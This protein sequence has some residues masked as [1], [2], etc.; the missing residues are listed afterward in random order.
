MITMMA[1]TTTV[2]KVR[3]GETIEQIAKQYGVSVDAIRQANP[4]M[5]EYFYIGMNLIIPERWKASTSETS[6]TAKV[7]QS[8]STQTEQQYQAPPVAEKVY[9]IPE[10]IQRKLE[11]ERKAETY[12]SSSYKRD[13]VYIS[14]HI[15]LNSTNLSGDGAKGMESDLGYSIGVSLDAWSNQFFGL[16]IG[17]YYNQYYIVPEKKYRM[18]MGYFEMELL[19]NI[20]LPLR[21]DLAALLEVNYGVSLNVGLSGSLYY[22]GDRIKGVEI[23][24]GTKTDALLKPTSAMLLT[25][26][27]FRWK[28]FFVRMLLHEGLTNIANKGKNKIKLS[29]WEFSLGFSY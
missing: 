14:S 29:S 22:D 4:N 5:G 6:T 21:K 28:D 3:K 16:E 10:P 26:F 2:H 13:N 8:I 23:I 27:T 11:E 25:G 12:T 1:Q 18:K 9:S 24:G 19:P 7:E 15:A 17:M 20:K